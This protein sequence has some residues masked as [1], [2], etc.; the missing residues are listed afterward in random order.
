MNAPFV[1]DRPDVVHRA[2]SEVLSDV[3]PTVSEEMLFAN[4]RTNACTAW[5]RQLGMYLMCERLG[6]TQ[7]TTATL[8]LRD[9]TTV[10]HA[11]LLVAE[12]VTSRPGTAAL[13]DLLEDQVRTKLDRFSAD[14]TSWGI[15]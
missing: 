5:V 14:E 8:F 4:G 12:Q 7:H 15:V 3:F 2:V 11:C 6:A 10:R 13:V 9:R 1:L